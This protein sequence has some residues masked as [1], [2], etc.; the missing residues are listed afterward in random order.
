MSMQE[1]GG[2]VKLAAPK[3][4]CY[5][6]SMCLGPM[7]QVIMQG[8]GL[9]AFLVAFLRLAVGQQLRS[10][11]AAPAPPAEALAYP[12]PPAPELPRTLVLNGYYSDANHSVVDLDRKAA[13]EAAAQS[14]ELF[15]K[16]IT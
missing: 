11:Y 2:L 16:R 14:L 6:G 9:I 10:P 15:V 7:R 8:V 5:F 3:C 1:N 4:V 12:C 13:Y